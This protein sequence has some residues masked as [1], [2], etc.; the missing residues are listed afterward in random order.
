MT[1]VF[2][3]FFYLQYLIDCKGSAKRPA[4]L[5]D[6]A[7][8]DS[9]NVPIATIKALVKQMASRSEGEILHATGEL[10]IL[11][12]NEANQAA[13]AKEGAIKPLINLL[14]DRSDSRKELAAWVEKSCN[15]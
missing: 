12:L 14:T 8:N 6:L 5:A 15:E 1:G 3:T 10:L 13:I 11:A 9:D 2:L 4:T 7:V